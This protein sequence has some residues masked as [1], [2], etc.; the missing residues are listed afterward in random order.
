MNVVYRGIT[1]HIRLTI[2]NAIRTEASA[3]GLKKIDDFGNYT[4]YPRAGRNVDILI[5][6][7]MP[8]NDTIYRIKKLRILH[9]GITNRNF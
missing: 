2:P 3:P 4:F 1:N 8:N 9:I 6:G 5:S 7:I